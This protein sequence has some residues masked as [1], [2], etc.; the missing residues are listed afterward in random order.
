MLMFVSYEL[1]ANPDVQQKLYEEVIE[2]DQQL[3]GKRITYDVL[4]KMK[5]LD[6]VIC[7]VLRKW[8]PAIQAIYFIIYT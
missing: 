5:Y 7:E 3:A 6:Q 2:T 4:Q 1:A 8:P